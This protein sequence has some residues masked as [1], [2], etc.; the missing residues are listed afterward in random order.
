M[1]TLK[2]KCNEVIAEIEVLMDNL[3]AY[4]NEGWVLNFCDKLNQLSITY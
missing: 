3:E 1:E 4:K 2:K